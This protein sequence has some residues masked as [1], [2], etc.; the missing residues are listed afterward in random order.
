MV[1]ALITVDNSPAW[2]D[3]L[4][5]VTTAITIV[6]GADYFFGFRS[7]VAARRAASSHPVEPLPHRDVMR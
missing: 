7:L 2:V 1:L 4:V 5:W 3:A 6:S